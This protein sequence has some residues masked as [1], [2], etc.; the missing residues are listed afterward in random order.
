M[1]SSC[2]KCCKSCAVFPSSRDFSEVTNEQGTVML[3]QCQFSSQRNDGK[4]RKLM[5]PL[6]IHSSAE[7]IKVP[8]YFSIDCLGMANLSSKLPTFLKVHREGQHLSWFGEP[9]DR[10]IVED[11]LGQIKPKSKP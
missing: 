10:S 6:S 2:S 1:G 11:L 5:I 8:I 9:I 7:F 3:D 4:K